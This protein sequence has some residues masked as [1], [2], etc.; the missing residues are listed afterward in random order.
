[1]IRFDSKRPVILRKFVEL[2]GDE[3]EDISDK[4]IEDWLKNFKIRA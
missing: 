1:L 4:D 3:M 2:I